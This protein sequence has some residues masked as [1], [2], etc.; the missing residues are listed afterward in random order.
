MMLASPMGQRLAAS[1][2]CLVTIYTRDMTPQNR[3]VENGNP[4]LQHPSFGSPKFDKLPP[5]P[6][7]FDISAKIAPQPGCVWPGVKPLT[8]ELRACKL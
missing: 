5:N 1:K 2:C 3:G 6:T 7:L 8:L 4:A